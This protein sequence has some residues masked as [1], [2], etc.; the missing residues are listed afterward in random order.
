MQGNCSAKP[1]SCPC[2]DITALSLGYQ[3]T[4]EPE[5]VQRLSTALGKEM[6]HGKSEMMTSNAKQ[7]LKSMLIVLM[8]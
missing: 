1:T 6:K 3:R 2:I 5:Q 4:T 8:A 7:G